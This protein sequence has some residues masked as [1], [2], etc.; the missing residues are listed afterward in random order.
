[1]LKLLSLLANPSSNA[2]P[3]FN[4]ANSGDLTNFFIPKFPP[5][6]SSKTKFE[7]NLKKILFK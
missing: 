4:A 6:S 7:L 1:M 3:T 5:V 2:K